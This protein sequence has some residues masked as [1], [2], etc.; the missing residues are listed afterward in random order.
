M[1]SP[2]FK[3]ILGLSIVA[4]I[5]ALEP[6]EAT[7]HASIEQELCPSVIN[8]SFVSVQALSAAEV[9]SNTSSAAAQISESARTAL[10]SLQSLSFAGTLGSNFD[11]TCHYFTSEDPQF[12][13]G[14]I[15]GRWGNPTLH[16]TVFVNSLAY[17]LFIDLDPNTTETFHVQ[18]GTRATITTQPSMDGAGRNPFVKVG[19]AVVQ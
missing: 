11:G 17:D 16:L 6:A 1:F 5:G 13:M 19:Y 4:S 9:S 2:R 12:P 18:S 3:A 15:T 8:L 7:T 10:D 14:E